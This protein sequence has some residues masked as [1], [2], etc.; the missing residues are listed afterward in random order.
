[1]SAKP[2]SIPTFQDLVHYLTR[3]AKYW[4][5]GLL[6][7]AMGLTL[8]LTYFVYGK[9]V[10]Y[11][12]SLFDYTFLDLP[13]KSE[14]SDTQ[15]N[16]RYQTI[17]YQL[18][19]ALNSKW[20]IE[21]T[22]MRLGLVSTA[23]QLNE[24]MK[25]HLEKIR[26]APVI[27]TTMEI[28]VRAYQ[29]RLVR[30]WPEAMLAEYR[31]Y[32]V[33]QR[34][35]HRDTAMKGYTEE[36]KRLRDNL[37]V[38]KDEE[39]KFEEQNKIIES[40][41]QQNKLEQL[42]TEMLTIRNQLDNMASMID[43]VNKTA[44]TTVEKLSLLKKYRK[45]PVP[46]GTI[47]RR[48]TPDGMFAK[49]SPQ[50]PVPGINQDTNPASVNT[51]GTKSSSDGQ[52]TVVVLP[53][54]SEGAEAWELD[55]RN[56]RELQRKYAELSIKFLPGHEEMRK[57]NQEMAEINTA[58]EEELK[59]GLKAFEVEREY[60]E[61]KLRDLESQMPEY[62][63]VVS[64][65]DTYRQDFRLLSQG[66]LG[67]EEAYQNLKR[68]IS[69][70]EYTGIDM[71]VEFEYHGHVDLRDSIPVGPNK[72]KLALYGLVLACIFG[73]G[74]PFALESLRCTTSLVAETERISRLSACGVVP[75]V[76]NALT[77]LN[78]SRLQDD[79]PAADTSLGEAFRIMRCSL[80]L[81]APKGNKVQVIM[82]CSSRASEGKTTIASNLARSCAL[83][84]SRTLIMDADMRRGRVHRVYEVENE[85]GL[86]QWLLDDKVTVNQ[87]I[88]RS[89]DQRL[90][91]ITRGE[92]SHLNYEALATERFAGLIKTL[93]ENYDKVIIDT[94]PIL[95]LADSLMIQH[96]ADGALLVI[97]AEQTTQRDIHTAVDILQ[98]SNTPIYG[99]V[100]NGIDLN[101]M[102]NSYYYRTYYPRYYDSNY[103]DDIDVTPP[104]HP[105][106]THSGIA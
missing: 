14:T 27:N 60:L 6:L 64:D 95:G 63:K 91:I 44:T 54:M 98:R 17:Q 39:Q 67:W 10:Y 94:P 2:K 83:A 57:L 46:V 97:R 22:A 28:E 99:F 78:P 81:Y 75:L 41:V 53:D 20:L 93:R 23:G 25:N 59:K 15:G 33:D 62:R 52:N 85:V 16:K 4:R 36:M 40:Y 74:G 65:F 32:L 100:L 35:R 92:L 66:Q 101:K 69:A 7:F 49:I 1:M 51:G 72:Q 12:R 9:P 18:I 61:G 5:V 90:D 80:P 50:Q 88:K 56:L 26:V 42:P 77:T 102:E 103:S 21:R 30:E 48:N 82:C 37:L 89:P 45:M 43:Y 55:E 68:R 58:L 87:I 3:G 86:S 38:Q 70:M 96:H 47:V 76:S 106:L 105:K 8:S 11:S 104:S 29:P 84:G 34:G 24:V 71:R 13:I 73:F 19:T 31:E 79:L